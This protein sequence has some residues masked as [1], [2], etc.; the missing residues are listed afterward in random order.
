MNIRKIL[1]A[2]DL[3]EASA[4]AYPYAAGLARATGAEI[5]ILYADEYQP[6]VTHQAGDISALVRHINEV[7]EQLMTE[8]AVRLAGWDLP[9]EVER[10]P[11]RAADVI[12]AEANRLEADVIVVS[13]HGERGL[14]RLFAGSTC[15]RVLR[16]S[17][18]PVLVVPARADPELNEVPRFESV[19]TTTDF[20]PDSDRGLVA[21]VALAQALD[22]ALDVVTVIDIPTI[23][24]TVT[25]AARFRI[26]PEWRRET[27]AKAQKELQEGLGLL[28]VHATA[29]ARL[30]NPDETILGVAL[31]RR[32]DLV[33]I[34]S[35][36]KGALRAALGSTS[37]SVI[38]NAA[39]PVLVLPRTW[40]AGV[41]DRVA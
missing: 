32:S 21:A 35:H 3:S 25:G 8:S 11:G 12:V 39:V 5:V 23:L 33:V 38:D 20:S 1:L 24:M 9:A 4:K 17:P 36:G 13:T 40:L 2:T 34:P 41:R 26:T 31:E 15:R 10:V 22:A 18:R 16:T 14:T 19:L 37:E 30:G 27:E 6:P 28:G 29:I 7:R